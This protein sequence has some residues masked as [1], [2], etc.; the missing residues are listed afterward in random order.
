LRSEAEIKKQIEEI[1]EKEKYA[2]NEAN[3][4]LKFGNDWY[5]DIKESEANRLL[6][7]RRILEWVLDEQI[8]FF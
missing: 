5:H 3:I 1:K 8:N 7:A 4:R 6:Y 2:R